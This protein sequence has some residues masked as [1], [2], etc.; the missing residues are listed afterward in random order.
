MFAEGLGW[1]VPD[2]CEGLG[3]WFPAPG[4]TGVRWVGEGGDESLAL[5]APDGSAKSLGHLR[6]GADAQPRQGAVGMGGLSSH[7]ALWA[8]REMRATQS[9]KR[10]MWARCCSWSWLSGRV[11]RPALAGRGT[12]PPSE[13]SCASG[14]DN[15]PF[16]GAALAGSPSSWGRRG[17][18]GCFLGL[19]LPNRKPGW[20]PS[21][22]TSSPTP[23]PLM[24]SC[25]S[26]ISLGPR[27]GVPGP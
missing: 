5:T 16:Q 18:P 12:W 7:P 14:A 24:G 19:L 23:F 10:Q 13:C 26:C 3:A 17:A 21:V 11:S 20:G 1:E 6:G 2:S 22:L 4:C 15:S 8:Q 27:G 9:G 25:H